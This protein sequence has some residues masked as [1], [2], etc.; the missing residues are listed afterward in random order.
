MEKQE[1]MII[2]KIAGTMKKNRAINKNRH[3]FKRELNAINNF[4]IIS[5]TLLILL[6][7]NYL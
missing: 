6:L 2:K 4:K 7:P 5:I 1:G 3:L